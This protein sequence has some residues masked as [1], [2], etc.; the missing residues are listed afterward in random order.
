VA[1]FAARG[2]RPTSTRC[3]PADRRRSSSRCRRYPSDT[4]AETPWPATAPSLFAAGRR[5]D[6]VP[7]RANGQ[8]AFGAYLRGPVGVRYATGFYVLTLA[9]GRICAHDPLRGQ[10][11]AV[12]RATALAPEPIASTGPWRGCTRRTSS[13]A[14]AGCAR[15][16]GTWRSCGGCWP[17][18]R[19]GSRAG[20]AT[21]A[22]TPEYRL[23]LIRRGPYGRYPCFRAG[24][25]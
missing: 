8:P 24:C 25:P 18:A 13:S 12:V 17:T 2:S 23:L 10:R 4:R 3:G 19:T 14:S 15:G 11:A 22:E 16:C 1:K 9:G 6:L 7:T 20:R 5:F 21:M